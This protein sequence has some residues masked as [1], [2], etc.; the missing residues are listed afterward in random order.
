MIDEDLMR[1]LWEQT[2]MTARE[3]AALYGTTRNA[4]IGRAYRRGWRSYNSNITGPGG[5]VLPASEARE[6]R[7]VATTSG[8]MRALD[9]RMDAVL[10]E[11]EAVLRRERARLAA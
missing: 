9:A 8:R 4:V 2:P 7:P 6:R 10:A 1:H 11:T 3:I 5:T